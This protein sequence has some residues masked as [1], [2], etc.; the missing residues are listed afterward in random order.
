MQ[1]NC[2]WREQLLRDGRHPQN[3]LLDGARW[4]CWYGEVRCRQLR[5]TLK[6]SNR[7]HHANC[8]IRD[9]PAKGTWWCV[10]RACW[11]R[12]LT[13]LS[14]TGWWAPYC[15]RIADFKESYISL[16]MRKQT[17]N[18]KPRHTKLIHP[19][20]MT[21]T[22]ISF[23]VE[24]WQL[25]PCIFIGMFHTEYTNRSQHVLDASGA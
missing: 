2:Y 23:M 5:T 17:Y 9:A 14:S 24:A 8:R 20:N 11:T 6:R 18:C 19:K 4:V 3:S 15:Y 1:R 12:P 16:R 13:L 21:P 7:F 22:L 25:F 10:R